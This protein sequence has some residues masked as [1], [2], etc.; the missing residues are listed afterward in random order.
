M[1]RPGSWGLTAST[2]WENGHISYLVLDV[3]NQSPAQASSQPTFCFWDTLHIWMVDLG[4]SSQYLLRTP[5]NDWRRSGDSPL[6][7]DLCFSIINS[8]F[9]SLLLELASRCIEKLVKPARPELV[10]KAELW[11]Q[12]VVWFWLGPGWPQAVKMWK[13]EPRCH[14]SFWINVAATASHL[15]ATP[16]EGSGCSVEAAATGSSLGGCDC[17]HVGPKLLQFFSNKNLK[18]SLVFV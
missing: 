7:G 15:S 13:H 2:L 18:N 8:R 6:L 14:F 17:E 3:C 1:F 5:S 4:R 10:F 9:W 11:L 12:A 16:W